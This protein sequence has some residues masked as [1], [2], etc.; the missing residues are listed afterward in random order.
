MP[1]PAEF[2]HRMSCCWYGDRR[3]VHAVRP[4]GINSLQSACGEWVDGDRARRKTSR[5]VTCAAC[6]AAL[7][8][9]SDA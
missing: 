4:V 2:K 6:V 9:G 5:E 8:E 3:T 1:D 7:E